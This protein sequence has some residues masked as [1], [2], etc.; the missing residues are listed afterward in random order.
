MVRLKLF[1]PSLYTKHATTF[2]FVIG[3]IVDMLLLPD[4]SNRLTQYIGLGYLFIIAFGIFLREWIVEGN[5]ASSFERILYSIV[6]FSIAFFSG[7]ALSF[8]FV[9]AI[10]GAAFICSVVNEVVA[11]H[12]YRFTLDIAVFFIALLF[13]I[14]FNL[15]IFAKTLS[16]GVFLVSLIVTS[17][18]G[19]L[20]VAFLRRFSEVA[21][22]EAPRAFALAVGIP[23]FVGM[24]YLLNVIPAVPLTLDRAGVYHS[25]TRYK[26]GSYSGRYEPTTSR[27][28]FLSPVIFH[29]STEDSNVYVFASI[30]APAL[31]KTPISHVWERY[32]ETTRTWIYDSTI[33]YASTGGRKEGYRG[34][35]YKE[36]VKAGFWRVTVKADSKRVV[37]RITFKV[38]DS[39]VPVETKIKP[40]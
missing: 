30:K 17:V 4:I 33:T 6:T 12:K 34:Y 24:L 29:K 7:S 18:I 3:F 25:V 15:P 36:S 23:M 8:I 1:S 19:I 20:Y 13:Y 21:H 16:G 32:D 28:S 11:S 5:R 35:S 9:Y 2:I 22:H 31:L 27:F 10:R 26:D 38:V 37:G 14:I 39:P 40:L